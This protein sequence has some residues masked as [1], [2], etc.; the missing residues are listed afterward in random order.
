M[1]HIYIYIYVNLSAFDQQVYV[2][3]RL[4]F[5]RTELIKLSSSYL[6]TV[7]KLPGTTDEDDEDED[8][9]K[10]STSTHHRHHHQQQHRCHLY[11]YQRTSHLNPTQPD[12]TSSDYISQSFHLSIHRPHSHTHAQ[13]TSHSPSPFPRPSI[14]TNKQHKTEIPQ[15]LSISYLFTINHPYH[16]NH[17]TIFKSS[18][19]TNFI[20]SNH[21]HTI[22]TIT[23]YYYHHH[24]P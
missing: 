6:S 7:N 8:D 1:L 23:H 3:F 5:L 22:S 19:L 17:S 15:S 12:L 9:S 2:C 21:I 4:S 11:L 24:Q 20:I 13:Y 18:S 10:Q 16:S 14:E